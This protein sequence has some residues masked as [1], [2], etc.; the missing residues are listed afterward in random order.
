M[1]NI[2]PFQD[3]IKS[4]VTHFLRNPNQDLKN[5]IQCT[6]DVLGLYPNIPHGQGYASNRKHSEN[7]ENKEDKTDT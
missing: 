3:Q 2:F 1:K 7:Q 5:T 6:I 4:Y